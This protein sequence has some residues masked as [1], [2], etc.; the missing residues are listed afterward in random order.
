MTS[1][2]EIILAGGKKLTVVGDTHGQFFDVLNLFQKF[3]F[4]SDEHV[5]LFNGD[6]VDR[7]SWSCEVA[8]YLFVLKILYP[9]SIFINRGNH[10]TNDMNKTY[11]FT[12]ECEHKY[13]QKVFEAFAES[14]GALPYAALIN[15][16]Y[17]CMHGGLFSR[18]DVTLKE[19]K[20]F[21]RFPTSGSTQ[22]PRDGIAMELLWTD[23][24]PEV[25]RSQS[26]RGIGMQFGP[27]ITERFCL[28]NKIRK[29]LRSHEVR[30]GGVEEEH[31]GRL[32]TVFS[33]PNYCD[34]TG[35]LG[36]VV[37]FVEN[38]K[39]NKATDQEDGYKTADD[40][41]CPWSLQIETFDAVPHPDLKPMAYSKS[42]FGY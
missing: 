35:N 27:D 9:H 36:G 10:E 24:Q 1:P 31:N 23:P 17:L 28:N 4:V 12:D 32:I 41:N 15:G 2:D 7:G 18:D 38:P 40:P 34:S 3:G 8:F 29:V 13:S 6:F 37:H 11:G 21:N 20:N 14:F 16:S 5:Y 33:A 25:G 39:Y 26:K 19:I 30:M 22:P 42:G